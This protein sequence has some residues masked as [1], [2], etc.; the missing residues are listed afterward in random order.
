MKIRDVT[1]ELEVVIRRYG[2][3]KKKKSPA[4]AFV[5]PGF[6][7]VYLWLLAPDVNIIGLV[8]KAEVVKE[9]NFAKVIQPVKM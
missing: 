1:T 4:K 9:V 7:L 2:Q 5:F 6:L 3:K 8:R